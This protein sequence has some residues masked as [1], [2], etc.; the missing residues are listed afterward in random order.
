MI[1]GGEMGLKVP[2][3]IGYQ[4]SDNMACARSHMGSPD[5]ARRWSDF[6]A[7]APWICFSR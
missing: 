3:P 1:L 7:I 5:Q 4:L 6:L 2:S